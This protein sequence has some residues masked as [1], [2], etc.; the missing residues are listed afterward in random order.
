MSLLTGAPE[1]EITTELERYNAPTLAAAVMS[2]GPIHRIEPGTLALCVGH[3]QRNWAVV[4]SALSFIYSQP[5]AI[6]KAVNSVARAEIDWESMS[7]DDGDFVRALLDLD[8]L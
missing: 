4:M 8:D 6:W 5:V 2:A 1:P 7:E 3:R